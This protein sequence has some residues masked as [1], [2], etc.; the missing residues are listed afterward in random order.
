M[1]N[2]IEKPG[3]VG[4]SQLKRE[5]SLTRIRL[6]TDLE[7]A[8]A[9]IEGERRAA[10][11]KQKELEAK[12]AQLETNPNSGNPTLYKTKSSA[13]NETADEKWDR[14]RD[15]A[16]AEGNTIPAGP[17]LVMAI[18]GI[19]LDGDD[20]CDKDVLIAL[21]DL[22]KSGYVTKGEFKKFYSRWKKS[23]LDMAAYLEQE[24]EKKRVEEARVAA[25]KKRK[26][27]EVKAMR[28]ADEKR[29][30]AAVRKVAEEEE[31]KRV[32]DEKRRQAAVRKAAE[33]AAEAKRVAVKKQMQA[34]A[35]SAAYTRARELLEKNG[36]GEL[37]NAAERGDVNMV[38]GFLQAGAQV[39][40]TKWNLF[41]PP[42]T[43]LFLATKNT[44][45]NT[46]E[47]GHLEIVKMLIEWGANPNGYRTK[48]GAYT[49]SSLWEAVQKGKVEVV[50]ALLGGQNIDVNEKIDFEGTFSPKTPLCWL[51][52][53][54]Q[55]GTTHT[56][57]AEL[58]KSAGG[59]NNG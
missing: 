1:P 30:Q 49:H 6:A 16:G 15:D 36:P 21:L 50:K 31:A 46:T 34:E 22:G 24:T 7:R 54:G 2:Y 33:E 53:Y 13:E 26:A 28:V 3:G 12:L 8:Q 41:I 17:N 20:V 40:F 4:G 51:A 48:T 5:G 52:K 56:V 18:E 58:L 9:Q 27:E 55:P 57:V 25:E 38:R 19:F 47:N 23:G 29:R 11:E 37:N 43:A 42:Y 59:Y 45:H 32:A 35:E 10:Q 39:D 14:L 44:S